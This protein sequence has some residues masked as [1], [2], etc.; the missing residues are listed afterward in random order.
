MATSTETRRIQIIADGSSVNASMQQMT[1]AARLLQNELK[2]L[3]ANSQE[4]ADKTKQFQ[5]VNNRLTSVRNE[6][7]GTETAMNKL[8]K[9]AMSLAG[10]FGLAFGAFELFNFFKSSSDAAKEFEKSLSSLSSLT[11]AVGEDLLFYKEQAEQIGLTTTLSA[12]QAVEAFTLMGSARPELLK[13]KEALAAVTAEAVTLAEAAGIDL[14]T[15]TQALAGTMNQFGLAADQASRVINA[16]AAG[17]KEGAAAIPEITAA[18][19]VFGTVAAQANGT[20]EESVGL[21]ETLAEKNLKGAEAGTKLRNMYIT[22][23]AEG[24]GFQSGVF[25][26]NDALEELGQKNLNV[27]EMT[28]LFGK[29]NVVAA[30]ILVENRAKVDQYTKAVTGTSVA[31][32]QAAI[33]TD[34]YAGDLKAMDSALEGV[35]IGIGEFLNAALRP[36]VQGFVAFLLAMKE[37]PKFIKDNRELIIGL[38]VAI[39]TLNAAN[40]ATA[41]STLAATAAEKGR[42]IAT[43]AS[44][45]ATRLLNAAMAANPIGLV[46]AAV[47]ALV[48]AFLY[49]Y[50]TNEKVRSAVHGTYEAIKAAFIGIKDAA[51]NIL[52]G[53]ADLYLGIFTL[54]KDR[55]MKGFEAITSSVKDVGTKTAAGFA[56]GYQEGMSKGNEEI[57]DTHVAGAAAVEAVVV[58]ANADLE[59]I[60]DEANAKKLEKETAHQERMKKLREDYENARLDAQKNAEDLAVQLIEDAG[61]RKQAKSDLDFDREMLALE[62]RRKAVLENEAIMN[63]EKDILLAAIDA[64][65]K[66][67]EELKYREDKELENERKLGDLEES[68]AL[69][70]EKLAELFESGLIAEAE[71]EERR[72]ELQKEF[73]RRKL[74]MLE[75]AG[76]GETAQA[77][78][79]KT[80]ILAIEKQIADGKIAEAQRAEAYKKEVMQIG[81][82][83]ARGFMQLGLDLLDE[84]SK[85]RK[86]FALASKALDIGMVVSSG[87]KEIAGYWEKTGTIPFVGAPMATALSIAAGIRTLGAVNKI[88]TAKYATGGMTGGGNMINMSMDANGT[89]RMPDGV[90]TR[91]V[92]SFARGGHV[93][94]ASFGVIGE[95]GAE[96]VGPN[97]MMRSPKYANIFG[98]LE[99]ERR[100][101]TP[102]AVGGATAPAPTI[103]SNGGTGADV[104]NLMAMM[105]Q[106]GDMSMKLDQMVM[107]IQEWPTRL[108]VVN[109]PRDILDGVR[110]LNEIEADSRI[111]R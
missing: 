78:K 51:L 72:L 60:Q 3:P 40:I 88:R 90:G 92:G 62:A 105:E 109:D 86:A 107:A 94:S 55:I 106:F 71:M 41:A 13:S 69:E 73:L 29:E 103:P 44:A 48:G 93:G 14:P 32:E 2:K 108:R 79:L 100:K 42:A 58:D 8:G 76:L 25:N 66:A 91:N 30:Q 33:N 61:A 43:Q 56:K 65:R 75:L 19:D 85:A 36:L 70:T 46:I 77:Q 39:L 28:K 104:Q 35:K 15:A 17:S 57:V 16:L 11:G 54:D 47:S 67:K 26:I 53:V 23:Q 84:D 34:N 10:S 83:N 81:F 50:R 21:I 98:Y 5:E 80:G 99:A 1:N 18:M 101:A 27:T 63:E 45:V 49:F 20:V 89:W 31:V 68:H 59:T 102:F 38:G 64:E 111:N 9:E 7:R 6:V 22:L 37:L 12:S 24:L 52:G 74:E 97:W 110:V 82:E 4:F 95:R 96:W 87:V